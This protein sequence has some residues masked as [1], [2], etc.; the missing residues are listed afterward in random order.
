MSAKS[1][2]KPA[3]DD[4]D[5][6]LP[7]NWRP[8]RRRRNPIVAFFAWCFGSFYLLFRIIFLG[9]LVFALTAAASYVVVRH[10]IKGKEVV[11]PNLAGYSVLEAL[12]LLQ[13]DT[14]ELALKLDAMEFNSMV[15]QGEI[16]STFPPPGSKVKA[17]STLRVKV[18]KGNTMVT[19]PNLVGIPLQDAELALRQAGLTEGTRI[20]QADRKVKRD[21]IIS[22][23]PEGG[24]EVSKQAPVNLVISQGPAA[25]VIQMPNLLAPPQAVDGAKDLLRGLGLQMPQ[26]L[27]MPSR[28]VADGTVILQ[29]PG[30][31][32]PVKASDSI[33][34]TVAKNPDSSSLSLPEMEI[35]E[36]DNRVTPRSA[37]PPPERIS[38]DQEDIPEEGAL[39]DE[40]PNL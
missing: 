40:L 23:D 4:Y 17:S 2:R 34:I 26:V 22:Q 9:A 35:D 25:P 12:S 7:D 28:G 15:N 24:A 27:E 5:Q 37:V 8:T 36:D 29:S 38:R 20:Y 1:S 3:S 19:C 32:S 33:T 11:V 10:Q 13:K 21:H 30:P 14:P 39:E 18:S 16:I 6:D 31:G